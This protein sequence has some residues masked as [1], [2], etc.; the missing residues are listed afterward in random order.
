MTGP[1]A[2]GRP[3]TS[4]ARPPGECWNKA[5]TVETGRLPCATRLLLAEPGRSEDWREPRRHGNNGEERRRDG[6]RYVLFAETD[7]YF[8]GK[9]QEAAAAP[10]LTRGGSFDLVYFP[11]HV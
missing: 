1:G 11:L 4:R 2:R 8:V 7:K 6:G 9:T 5:F 10:T 3:L